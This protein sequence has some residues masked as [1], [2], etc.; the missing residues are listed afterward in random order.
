MNQKTRNIVVAV[1]M[2]LNSVLIA[3]VVG[4]LPFFLF[5]SLTANFIAFLYVKSLLEEL[6]GT[7]EDMGEIAS[8]VSTFSEHIEKIY[9]M[10][11]FYGDT[12]LQE[13]MQHSQHV[14]EDIDNY[15][16]KQYEPEE[17][18]KETDFDD[19]EAAPPK[20]NQ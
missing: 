9:E 10:E 17:E 6:D 19:E 5:L 14:V 18:I 2:L 15:I 8:S 3:V 4:T 13:L 16:S 11:T 7:R 12:V 20:D 1:S